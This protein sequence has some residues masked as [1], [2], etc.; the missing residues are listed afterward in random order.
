MKTNPSPFVTKMRKPLLIITLILFALSALLGITFILIAP[1]DDQWKLLGTT[2]LF[3]FFSL[4]TMNNL[5][6]LV[7]SAIVKIL[8]ISAIVSNIIWTSLIL[9]LT[10]GPWDIFSDQ[11]SSIY[12]ITWL[13]IGFSICATLTGSFLFMRT[14][15]TFHLT[16]KIGSIT[17][18]WFLYIYYIPA[19]L[20]I[21]DGSYLSETWQIIAIAGIFFAFCTISTPIIGR[22]KNSKT[23]TNELSVGPDNISPAVRAQIEAE[24]R[25]KLES[26]L[27]EKITREL[28]EKTESSKQS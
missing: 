18:A 23:T 21:S 28:Q 4:F 22:I 16:T 11:F 6:R 19:I 15:S 20:K 2:T 24:L 14:A 12:Q 5:L 27:R 13:A 1:H 9:I 3:S 25:P 26:E 10:W 17:A 8:A 7:G